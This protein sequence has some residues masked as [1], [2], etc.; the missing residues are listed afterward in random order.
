MAQLIRL[1]RMVALK[2]ASL[3]T[4]FEEAC[5]VTIRTEERPSR[6]N[7]WQKRTLI[8]P[9]R[10][11]WYQDDADGT[12]AF[13]TLAG[14]ESRIAQALQ[15]QQVPL[16]RLTRVDDRLGRPRFDLLG[17]VQMREK[18]KEMLIKL[19]ANPC[20]VFVSAT[21]SG[22]ST[23]IKWIARIY[24]EASIIITAPAVD[25]ARDLYRGL[26]SDYQ[27][28]P[29][30]IGFVGDG[31]RKP[32]RITVAVSH[33]LEYCD[34]GA[35]LV[36]VDE[37]HM[38]LTD[39][40]MRLLNRFYRARMF[41]FSASPEG[42]SD[43]SDGYL[44]A[45][46]GPTLAESDYQDS[47]ELGTVAQLNVEMVRSTEGPNV[48]DLDR[49]DIK[50]KRAIIQNQA[51]NELIAKHVRRKQQELGP[52]A[53]ILVMVSKTEHAYRLQQLLPE[54]QVVCDTI[55]SARL[56]EL[57]K[58]GAFKPET[59]RPCLKQ[60]RAAAKAA[61]EKNELKYVI[62]TGVWERGV[63]F[64]DLVCLVRADAQTSPIKCCQIPGRLSRLGTDGQKRFGCLVDLHDSFSRDFEAK[65]KKRRA[66]Y[67]SHGWNLQYVAP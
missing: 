15:S 41:G 48:A 67:R 27:I 10:L 16:E 42:K 43:G 11:W 37:V 60:D 57:V 62:C 44:E 39:R 52:D 20:G 26:T 6:E 12:Q 21:G 40:F 36:L 46:F 22:K 54:F 31:E 33:S 7:G 3:G 30:Q 28:P 64:K 23:L 32:R 55:T 56:E 58:C 25:N 18:Q 61:Y 53:Q 13:C 8:D 51:R 9:R 65:S 66:A 4:Q 1:G 19:A 35:S 59:Q 14:Y 63:D 50:E 17:P 49:T 45:I 5:T 47:V 2:P 29:D 38:A 34:D 24:P